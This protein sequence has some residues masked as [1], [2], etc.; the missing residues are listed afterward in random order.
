MKQMIHVNNEYKH[1]F[2]FDVATIYYSRLQK[3]MTKMIVSDFYLGSTTPRPAL[4]SAADKLILVLYNFLYYVKDLLE[5]RTM[6][7]KSTDLQSF[8][9]K[10]IF[11]RFDPQK[12]NISS[13]YRPLIS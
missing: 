13:R 12:S 4:T 7:K 3:Q 2:C 11:V 5:T 6:E 10:L 1:L 9:Q 8:E